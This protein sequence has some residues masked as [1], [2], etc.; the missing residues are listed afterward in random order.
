MRTAVVACIVAASAF[1]GP[2]A[3]ADLFDPADRDQFQ[4]TQGIFYGVGG[5]TWMAQSFTAGV[6]GTLYGIEI[7]NTTEGLWEPVS[8]P[9][10]QIFYSEPG[11]ASFTYAADPGP[12]S[13]WLSDADWPSNGWL[14][15][16]FNLF[17]EDG[18]TYSIVVY[19]SDVGGVTVGATESSSYGL[20][21]LWKSD[22]SG[23]T[24]GPVP[25][26]SDIQFQTYVTAV[27]APAGVFLG[28]LG[29]VAAGLHLRR[30]MA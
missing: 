15:I 11:S 22:N 23:S 24:W 16:P 12:L 21:A 30:Q 3:R 20:G 17:V 5:P 26:V 19:A 4:M 6:T 10:V 29:L 27:P 8:T 18:H 13:D 1:V 9:V 7:G 14:G 2:I 28:I 25:G